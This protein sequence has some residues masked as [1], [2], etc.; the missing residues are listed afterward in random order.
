MNKLISFE[1]R[2]LR[3]SK[4]YYILTAV[5]VLLVLIPILTAQLL[6]NYI[7]SSTGEK[8]TV[9][10]YSMAKSSL[11]ESYFYIVAIFTAMFVVDDVT[12]GTMKNIIGKG[13]SR[14]QVYFSKYL[15]SLGAVLLMSLLT[16]AVSFFSSWIIW[17]NSEP[18]GDN[19]PLIVLGQLLG[20]A[21]YHALFFTVSYFFGKTGPAISV[22]LLGPMLVSLVLSLIN[23]LLKKSDFKLSDYWLANL[24]E[25]FTGDTD[26]S[27]ILPGILLL[28]CYTAAGILLGLV[29]CKKKEY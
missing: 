23:L 26:T 16:V 14:E 8:L 11:N 3:K 4:Y 18:I 20:V 5:S 1:A 25:N 21:A 17:G 7:T 22:C 15:V 10:A 24:H 6:N 9:S 28:A 2:K 29:F 19:V 13:Y 27:M 12:Q